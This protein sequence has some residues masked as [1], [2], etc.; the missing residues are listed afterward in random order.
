LSVDIL[1]L[2]SEAA[3]ILI[4]LLSFGVSLIICV[5]VGLYLRK[6]IASPINKL[7]RATGEMVKG[8]LDVDLHVDTG[9]EIESFARSLSRMRSS[10]QIAIDML[11]PPDMDK[12]ED[13]REITGLAIGEK[14]VFALLL[15]LILNPIVTGIPL[16]LF[17]DPSAVEVLGISVLPLLFSIMLVAIFVY[18]LN[19][20]IMNPFIF[21]TKVVDRV[22]K[23]EFTTKVE[24]TSSGDVGRLEQNFKLITERI[25]RAMGEL[26]SDDSTDNPEV[27]HA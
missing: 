25:Q 10:L 22:S 2:G 9:D 24:V 13:R 12:Y 8:N 6:W 21:L 3:D 14:I 5:I 18:H 23:G 7:V 19:N 17:D 4:P 11:G 15:F 20:S 16:L 1:D 26:E 27:P